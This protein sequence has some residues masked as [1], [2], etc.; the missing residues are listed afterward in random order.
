MTGELYTS[1]GL[2]AGATIAGYFGARRVG[3][4]NQQLTGA[5]AD[6]PTLRS[7]VESIQNAVDRIEVRQAV[8]A[9]RMTARM[10]AFED[11]MTRIEERLTALEQREGRA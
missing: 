10:D 4:V 1:I 5:T 11:R 2:L 3:K 8:I 9:E 7:L 6:S